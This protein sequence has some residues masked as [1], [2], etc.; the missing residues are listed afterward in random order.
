MPA[1]QVVRCAIRLADDSAGKRIEINNAMIAITT[2]NSISVNPRRFME[3]ILE[4][5]FVGVL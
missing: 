3:S 2:S 1:A 5:D 4:W